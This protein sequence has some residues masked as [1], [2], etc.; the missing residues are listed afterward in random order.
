VGGGRDVSSSRY[1]RIERLKV[2]LLD[3]VI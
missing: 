1:D 2:T 3:S